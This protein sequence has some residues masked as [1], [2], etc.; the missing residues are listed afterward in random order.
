MKKI[1]LYFGS[2]NPI[3]ITHLT[4]ANYIVEHTDLD[5][6]ELVVSPQNPFK[7]EL[8]DFSDRCNMI[9]KAISDYDKIQLNTIEWDL[10]V[11]S[12]TIDTLNLLKKTNKDEI[13]YY[14]IMGMDNWTQI[15]KWKSYKIVLEEY[16]IYVVP[17][18][19]NYE[20]NDDLFSDK[21][22]DLYDDGISVNNKTKI[23]Y[24]LPIST[25][26]A[27]FIRNEIKTGKN[28]TPYV[29]KGVSNYIKENKLYI[30]I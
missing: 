22:A 14:I 5:G 23:I 24:G 2:F 12:Y 21:L 26:S 3:H 29:G 25:L 6:V 30:W 17:R 13:E 16:P 4:I 20:I 28:V 11:P 19:D 9:V 10:P 15:H 7:T 27:S 8:C 1:G 18:D